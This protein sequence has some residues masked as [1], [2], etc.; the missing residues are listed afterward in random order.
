M[1]LKEDKKPVSFM[2]EV[3]LGERVRGAVKLDDQPLEKP[4]YFEPKK[5]VL[6]KK[7]RK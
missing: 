2:S 4:I 1:G 5:V 7:L 3:Q 6:R